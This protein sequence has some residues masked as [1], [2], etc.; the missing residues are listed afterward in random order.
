M[1]VLHQLCTGL[2][3]RNRR[4]T[5]RKLITFLKHLLLQCVQIHIYN[6]DSWI[7]DAYNSIKV[8][9][10]KGKDCGCKEITGNNLLY[11]QRVQGIPCLMNEA[12]GGR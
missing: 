8:R 2:A 12:N 11:T 6:S 9:D 1:Q 3:T 10:E 7:T 4:I 5:S